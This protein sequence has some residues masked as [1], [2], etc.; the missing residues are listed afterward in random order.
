MLV[1][2]C[3]TGFNGRLAHGPAAGDFFLERGTTLPTRMNGEEKRRTRARLKALR[4]ALDPEDVLR[5]GARV[6]QRVLATSE[7]QLARTVALYAALDG[8]VPTDALL[9]AAF[10]DKKTVVFPT[11][12]SEG[13]RLTF[14]SVEH[15]AHL[16]RTGRLAILEPLSSRPEVELLRI[17]LFVVPGLGFS[18]QGDR[19]GRGAGYYDATLALASPWTPRMG[20]AFSEQVLDAL[21]TDQDD[22]PMHFVV[23]EDATF[24]SPEPPAPVVGA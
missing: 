6:Q 9:A 11:V 22:V 3:L 19:L 4:R 23:T 8:E 12:P 18:R 16:E 15:R 17:D 14:R 24:A 7:Y 1:P 13:R 20:V 5:R 10:R 21:P 2:T